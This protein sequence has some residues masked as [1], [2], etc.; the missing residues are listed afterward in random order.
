MISDK[1]Q[2]DNYDYVGNDPMSWQIT[3]GKLLAAVEVLKRARDNYYE[4]TIHELKKD[5][6]IPSEGRILNS[7][8]MLRG[9]AME[10]LLKGVYVK[11]GN[12]L[13]ANGRLVKIQGV[14]SH[15]LIQLAQKI[16]FE[17]TAKEQNLLMRLEVYITSAGRYPISDF[18][19]KTKIRESIG[20]PPT[21]WTM[22]TDDIMYC[23]LTDRLVAEIE[24]T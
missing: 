8:I 17:L 1:R 16:H 2:I 23:N 20:G 21:Y 3:A 9:F 7:E 5:D 15:K 24:H 19:E 11:Q 18:W 4:T 14:G 6:P 12:K 22:P 10:C 13:A